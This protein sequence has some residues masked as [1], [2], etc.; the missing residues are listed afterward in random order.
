MGRD[1]QLLEGTSG[2]KSAPGRSLQRKEGLVG[3]SHSPSLE[4]AAGLSWL[5]QWG[6]AEG[7]ARVRLCLE[8]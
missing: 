3:R 2:R 4:A 7:Q 5:G 1:S 6:S 8:S